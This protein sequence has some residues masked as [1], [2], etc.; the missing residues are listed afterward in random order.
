[1]QEEERIIT[2]TMMEEIRIEYSEPKILDSIWSKKQKGKTLYFIEATKQR[3]KLWIMCFYMVLRVW[4]TI[5]PG[6]SLM[7]WGWVL[8]V[9]WGPP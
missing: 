7:N 6:S 8:E 4:K 2:S 5:K 1:M 3:G 9:T